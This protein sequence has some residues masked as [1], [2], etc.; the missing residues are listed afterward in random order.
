VNP[1]LSVVLLVAALKFREPPTG[2]VVIVKV[3][4]GEVSTPPFAVPPL[5]LR[6][7]VIV[8]VPPVFAAGV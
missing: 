8:A 6:F 4:D 7:I 1:E 5:S 2:V 3:C